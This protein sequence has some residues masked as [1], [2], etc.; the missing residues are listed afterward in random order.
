MKNATYRRNPYC[1]YDYRGVEEHLSTMAAQGWRLEKAGTTFWKY[2]RA[3]PANL[4]YAVTYSDSASQYNPGPTEDQRFL[5]DLCAAAGW[6]KVSDWFQMQIFSTE[7]PDAVPLETDEALRLENIHRSMKKNF[8]PV[9]TVLLFL[10]LFLSRDFLLALA[11]G[12]LYKLLSRNT[13]LLIGPLA[14]ALVAFQLYTLCAYFLWRRRSL[15]SVAE[16]GVCLPA[17]RGYRRGNLAMGILLLTLAPA[18]LLLEL[19]LGNGGAALYFVLYMVLFRL[20]HLVVLKTTSLLRKRQVS[21]TANIAWTLAVDAVL[22]AALLGGLLYGRVFLG[23]F[24]DGLPAGETYEYRDRQWDV[25]PRQ[26][27][28]LTLAELTGEEYGHVRR[29]AE[30]LGSVFI[31]QRAYRETALLG[32]GP[33]VCGLGYT[34]WDLSSPALQDSLLED[35]LED[36]PIKFRGMLLTTLRYVPEDP[37]PWGA[38][39]AYRRYY[40]EDP[41]DSWL[42]VWPGR[43]ASVSPDAEP[44]D[45]QKALIS[46]RL[47]PEDWKEETP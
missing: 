34:L 19:G 6:T 9:N 22:C 4:R 35:L 31:P 21:K 5:A 11:T 37:V 13:V 46:A 29:E 15:R 26:D 17:G 36:D 7:D 16:G 28:P 32:D 2:R 24:S 27:F 33:K 14:L 8:I 38:E 40:D 3:D 30:D 44:A 20:I 12:N 1:L 42:L 45:T 43:A 23:W 10:M 41:G 25:S 18:Y 47:A 39:A